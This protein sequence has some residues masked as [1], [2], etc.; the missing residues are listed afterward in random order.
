MKTIET[1]CGKGLS[2][3]IQRLI[4]NAPAQTT[5]NGLRVRAKYATTKPMDVSTQYWRDWEMRSFIHKHQP[6]TIKQRAI[7]AAKWNKAKQIAEALRSS[8]PCDLSDL[9]A[10]LGWLKSYVLTA[11]ECGQSVVIEDRDRWEAA[12]YVPDMNLHDAFNG[13]DPIN[14]AGYIVGQVMTYPHPNLILGFI[15]QWSTKFGPV[16]SPILPSL[17]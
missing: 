3:T 9:P 7:D 12:G 4:E 16:K 13:E 17:N 8:A 6:A 11:D 15:E 2:E 1:V 14:F 5:F 10:V